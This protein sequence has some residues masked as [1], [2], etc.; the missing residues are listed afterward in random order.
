MRKQLLHVCA[1]AL[2]LVALPLFGQDPAAA[3][4]SEALLEDA[5]EYASRVGVSIDEAVRRLRLQ[6]QIGDLE[7]VLLNEEP[8]TYAGLWIEDTPHY[9]VI[10]RFTDPAAAGRLRARVAGGALEELIET[11]SARWSLA[12]LEKRQ[13]ESRGIARGVKIPTNSKVNVAENRVELHVLDPAKFGNAVAAAKAR[14]PEGVAIQ[15]VSRLAGSEA[16]VGGTSL[17]T[18]TAGFTVQATTGELGVSTAGHCQNNQSFQVLPLQFLSLPFRREKDSGEFDIQWHSA[19]DLVQVTNQFQTGLGLRSVVGT[20]HRNNQAVGTFVCK[21]GGVTGRTC[22]WI[23]STSYDPNFFSNLFGGKYIYVDGRGADLSSNGDSGGP[24]YVE[25]IAYGIHSGHGGN[26]KNAYYMAINYIS[27]VGVSVLTSNP[28]ACNFIPIA[29]FG[30]HARLDGF[31]TFNGSTSSD[32]DGFIVRWE[33]NFDDGTTA[34]STTPSIT[35]AYPP[36]SGSYIVTLTVTDNEGKRGST[37]KEVCV[38]TIACNVV[39]PTP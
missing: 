5:A 12:E 6:T 16:L 9:R 1:L 23:D 34:V 24:W 31:A 38:P 39:G 33:W 14:I 19:C 37:A 32:P 17:T 36:N 21:F 18:C 30:A 4:P 29:N 8:A 25:D 15:R 10:A 7:A 11:R 27:A 2:A 13:A 20:R 26:D 28:G 3:P 22:G 35:H